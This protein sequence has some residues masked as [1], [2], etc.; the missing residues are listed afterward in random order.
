LHYAVIYG[1]SPVGLPAPDL[2]KNAKKEAWDDKF[3][4]TLQEIA[5]DAVTSNPLTGVKK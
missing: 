2:L 5:W 3:N 1:R 4:R